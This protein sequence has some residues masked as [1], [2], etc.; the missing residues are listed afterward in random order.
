MFVRIKESY[1]SFKTPIRKPTIQDQLDNH[2][3]EI[4][5]RY[6]GREKKVRSG[7][8]LIIVLPLFFT[9]T[10][11]LTKLTSISEL[12]SIFIGGFVGYLIAEF[13][14]RIFKYIPFYKLNPYFGNKIEEAIKSLKGVQK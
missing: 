8:I 5:E 12:V 10:H 2:K 9:F 6:R 1:Y 14:D 13:G 11:V 4:D 3:K 7:V